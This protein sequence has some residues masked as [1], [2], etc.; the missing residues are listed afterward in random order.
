MHRYLVISPH[1][2]EDCKMA[3]KE[4]RKYNAGFLTHFE[5]G[6]LDDD[7][8][9]YAIIE[10]ESH[11]NAKMSVPTIFREKSRVIL[12]TYFDPASEEDKLHK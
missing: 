5:W 2:A 10:A 8:T 1:T 9:A 3:I 4:F 11:E 7:H 6:C 12:L